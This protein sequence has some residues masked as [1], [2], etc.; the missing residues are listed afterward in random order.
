MRQ[1]SS[2]LAR[3]RK[4]YQAFKDLDTGVA[5]AQGFYSHTKST[6]ESISE[7]VNAFVANRK[8]EGGDLLRRIENS[9]SSGTDRQADQERERLQGLMERM[10]MNDVKST[11]RSPPNRPMPQ[12]HTSS[13]QQNYSPMG[14]S[15]AAFANSIY[16]QP[17]QSPY[18]QQAYPPQVPTLVASPNYRATNSG[19]ATQPYNPS[20][21]GMTSPMAPSPYFSPP[22]AQNADFTSLALP[23]GYVPPP[24]PP[25][26]PPPTRSYPA[27]NGQG[28]YVGS[29]QPNQRQ[30]PQTNK[31]SGDPWAG[32]SGW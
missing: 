1:K 30:Q 14:S 7:N 20:H 26:G 5:R 23:T 10:N 16:A 32:L 13:Y 9:R 17:T 29:Y 15:P 3:Y 4:I 2:V 27:I 28:N 19:G 8:S 21:Y 25:G 24:P 22:V 11:P 6:V 18:P 12:Q 31:P